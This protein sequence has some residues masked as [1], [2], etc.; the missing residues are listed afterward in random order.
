MT[1]RTFDY[2]PESPVEQREKAIERWKNW[3]R[4]RSK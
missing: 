3:V 1:Q 4:E 2:N